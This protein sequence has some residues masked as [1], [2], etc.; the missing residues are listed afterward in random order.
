MPV[1]TRNKRASVLGLAQPSLL[2][3]PLPDGS[4]TAPDRLH[5]AYLYAGIAASAPV[6]VR[7]LV[8]QAVVLRRT[9]AAAV[10]AV[11]SHRT[12][13]KAVARH[14]QTVTGP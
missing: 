1:D 4:I 11:A 7:P 13:A 6:V 8:R 12:T 3:P 5:L 14:R 2:A 10:S 9:N